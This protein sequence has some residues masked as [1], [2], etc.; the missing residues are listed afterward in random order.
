MSQCD[1]VGY[2]GRDTPPHYFIAGARYMGGIDETGHILRQHVLQVHGPLPGGKRRIVCS[3]AGGRPRCEEELLLAGNIIAHLLA[4]ER[5][6]MF[7]AVQRGLPVEDSAAAQMPPGLLYQT[8]VGQIGV[9]HRRGKRLGPLRRMLAEIDPVG[10]LPVPR[11]QTCGAKPAQSRAGYPDDCQIADEHAEGV[12]VESPPFC[13]Y[14]AIEGIKFARTVGFVFAD[15]CD[16]VLERGRGVVEAVIKNRD[17]RNLSAAQLFEK[18]NRVL[19]ADVSKLSK[20]GDAGA[21]S[22]LGQS[23]GQSRSDSVI[24]R[25]AIAPHRG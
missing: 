7:S 6:R 18:Q 5:G 11:A 1:K 8:D 22:G 21:D 20:I 2:V 24:V 25:R 12:V 9:D 10:G 3:L 4:L 17:V 15:S 19:R 16:A 14:F 23:P 13:W